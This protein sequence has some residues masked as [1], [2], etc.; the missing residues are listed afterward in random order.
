MKQIKAELLGSKTVTE[1]GALGSTL[2]HIPKGVLKAPLWS[3]RT[4]LI[5]I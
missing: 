2:P 3:A 1:E 5:P 4:L